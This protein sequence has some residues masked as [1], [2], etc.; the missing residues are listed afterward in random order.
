M[1]C[2]DCNFVY[3]RLAPDYEALA[4]DLAW[5]KTAA[6]EASGASASGSIVSTMQPGFA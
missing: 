2:T 3:L 6:K 5:E 4:E 1:Q